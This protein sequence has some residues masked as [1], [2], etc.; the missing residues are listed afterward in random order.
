MDS[1]PLLW[2]IKLDN[3]CIVVICK[4]TS[5]KIVED[6]ALWLVMKMQFRHEDRDERMMINLSSTFVTKYSMVVKTTSKMKLVTE[7]SGSGYLKLLGHA[8]IFWKCWEFV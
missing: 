2:D 7:A 4:N 1:K 8:K 6:G 3:L 5:T